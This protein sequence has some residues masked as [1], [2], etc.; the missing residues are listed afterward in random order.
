MGV[1][2]NPNV[3]PSVGA[4]IPRPDPQT[5]HPNADRSMGI[6]PNPNVYELVGVESKK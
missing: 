3:H 2:P 6:A 5:Q 1:A 4:R